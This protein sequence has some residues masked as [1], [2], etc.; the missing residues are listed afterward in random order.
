MEEG[1]KL[2][3][4]ILDFSFPLSVNGAIIRDTFEIVLSRLRYAQTLDVREIYV[5]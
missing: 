4:I 1:D 3:K 5:R 2:S